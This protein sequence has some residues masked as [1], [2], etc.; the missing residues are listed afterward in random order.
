MTSFSRQGCSRVAIAF[1]VALTA[2][3]SSMA[4]QQHPTSV[5]ATVV[6]I[7]CSAS[8]AILQRLKTPLSPG[9]YLDGRSPSLAHLTEISPHIFAAALHMA[10]GFH[11]LHVQ[12]PNGLGETTVLD[13]VPGHSRH[14]TLRVCS[15]AGIWDSFRSV[16]VVL[17][18]GGLAASL[19]VA[20]SSGRYATYAMQIDDGVAY[21]TAIGSGAIDL[22]VSYDPGGAPSIC[23]Y[24]LADASS[25]LDQHL[26]FNLPLPA[27][28]NT[29]GPPFHCGRVVNMHFTSRDY[30][31]PSNGASVE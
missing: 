18:V 4:L 1:A 3:T 28:R 8:A 20:N 24:H 21:A 5:V 15:D 9:V 19:L 11:R 16:T 13:S 26:R 12:T 7:E 30:R 10:P 17:P 2:T 29:V 6:A 27:L 23:S 25:D 31:P 22:L 14:V